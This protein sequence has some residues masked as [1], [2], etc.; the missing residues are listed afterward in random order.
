MWTASPSRSHSSPGEKGEEMYSL[1]QK[2]DNHVHA[3]NVHSIHI[4][5]CVKKKS[6]SKREI[7]NNFTQA[8]DSFSGKLHI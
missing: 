4:I 5:T 3:A 7:L 2:Q 6:L 1:S 8:R